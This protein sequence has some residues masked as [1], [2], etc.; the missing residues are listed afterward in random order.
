MN[1]KPGWKTSEFWMTILTQAAS[2]LVL[3][4]IIEPGGEA[5]VQDQGSEVIEGV[6]ALI[7]MAGSTFGYARARGDAKKPPV[8]TPV[9]PIPVKTQPYQSLSEVRKPEL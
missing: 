4:G 5:A 7:A 3:F 6:G 1:P 8:E 2:L 9:Q